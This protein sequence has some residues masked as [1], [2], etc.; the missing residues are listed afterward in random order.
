[1]ST[2]GRKQTWQPVSAMSALKRT[3]VARA[4]MSAL[5]QKLTH[6]LQQKQPIRSPCRRAKGP[7]REWSTRAPSRS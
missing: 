6:A 4:G 7:I 2:L 3:L 1:M 5:C